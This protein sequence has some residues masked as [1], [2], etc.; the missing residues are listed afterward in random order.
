M[1][2]YVLAILALALALA[3]V[4]VAAGWDSRRDGRHSADVLLASWRGAGGKLVNARLVGAAVEIGLTCFRYQLDASLDRHVFCFDGAGRLVEL[5]RE[6]RRRVSLV[7]V[8]TDP[9]RAPVR[10]PQ[11]DLQHATAIAGNVQLL[12]AS[13]ATVRA[14]VAACGAAVV[15]AQRD[16]ASVPALRQDSLEITNACHGVGSTLLHVAAATGAST[17]L[18]KLE[19]KLSGLTR[20]TTATASAYLKTNEAA[21]PSLERA[22]A[23]TFLARVDALSARLATTVTAFA[24]QATLQRARLVGG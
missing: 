12:D 11:R 9:D 19:T 17:P 21:A 1:K 3:A 20:Q 15:R 18:A 5:L 2:R 13:A 16:G 14:A 22:A 10:L 24:R 23:K 7:S 8:S 6:T 4:A